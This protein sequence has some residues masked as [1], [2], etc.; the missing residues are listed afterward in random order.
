[1]R[2]QL[3]R[4]GGESWTAVRRLEEMALGITSGMDSPVQTGPS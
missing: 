2:V 4:H 1:V 3:R